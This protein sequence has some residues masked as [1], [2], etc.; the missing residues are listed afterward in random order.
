[1]RGASR[2]LMNLAAATVGA[3]AACRSDRQR[4]TDLET[5]W[6]PFLGR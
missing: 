4:D 3:V 1:M 6:P 5:S 2:R